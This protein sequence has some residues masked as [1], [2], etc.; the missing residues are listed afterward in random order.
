MFFSI[1]H[2]ILFKNGKIYIRRC[3]TAY[4]A[5]QPCRLFL[6]TIFF[7]FL[8]TAFWISELRPDLVP[9]LPSFS[10]LTY[11]ISRCL[12]LLLYSK[13]KWLSF[14]SIVALCFLTNQCYCDCSSF[15]VKEEV[16]N[17]YSKYSEKKPS[18]PIWLSLSAT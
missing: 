12:L 13:S 4:C 8:P 11:R 18:N 6:E 5:K 14:H 15:K 2:R 3:I 1:K 9:F 10:C 17:S 7:F 16:V